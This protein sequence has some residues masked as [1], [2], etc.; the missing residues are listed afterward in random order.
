MLH[1]PEI[2]SREVG[3]LGSVGILHAY[4]VLGRN[5]AFGQKVDT[6]HAYASPGK[7]LDDVGLR[8]SFEWSAGELIVGAQ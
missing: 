1:A 2:F 3:N 6:H 7:L 8:E 5:H 4:A